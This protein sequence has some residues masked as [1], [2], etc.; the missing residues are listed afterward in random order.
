MLIDL[1]TLRCDL[2]RSQPQLRDDVTVSNP[3]NHNIAVAGLNDEAT[4]AEES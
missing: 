4:W 1:D 2:A 3:T